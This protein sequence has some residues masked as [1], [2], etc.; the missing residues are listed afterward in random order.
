MT[1]RPSRPRPLPHP[2]LSSEPNE[3]AAS[4]GA[5]TALSC[6]VW[7]LSKSHIQRLGL[8]VVDVDP[9]RR[10]RN[11]RPEI[12]R[13]TSYLPPWAPGCSVAVRCIAHVRA[14]I[15]GQP[16]VAVTDDGW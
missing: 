7:L 1:Y 14:G 4:T 9:E 3:D 10:P 13:Y 6:V 5:S 12:G 15:S 2:T 16:R 11:D 8:D